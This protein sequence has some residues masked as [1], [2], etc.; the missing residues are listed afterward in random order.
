MNA[1]VEYIL[2]KL[3]EHGVP[4]SEGRFPYTYHHDCRRNRA[5]DGTN[6]GFHA[7]ALHGYFRDQEGGE[8]AAAVGA[9]LY[10]LSAYPGETMSAMMSNDGDIFNRLTALVNSSHEMQ[11]YCCTFLGINL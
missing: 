7:T 10:L 1:D 11:N 8:K 9:V 4:I 2:N 5:K 3:V 6:R